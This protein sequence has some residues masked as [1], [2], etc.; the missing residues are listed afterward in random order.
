MTRAEFDAL[1]NPSADNAE[2]PCRH[3]PHLTREE[4]ATAYGVKPVR[5]VK[6]DRPTK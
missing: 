1:F 5:P 2:F 6:H 3:A 4:V